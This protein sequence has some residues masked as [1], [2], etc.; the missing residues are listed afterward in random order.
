MLAHGVALGIDWA[1]AAELDLAAARAAAGVTGDTG[2]EGAAGGPPGGPAGVTPPATSLT[3]AL[4]SLAEA[5]PAAPLPAGWCLEPVGASTVRYRNK[6][7]GTV[8]VN[9]HPLDG[10]YREKARA[11][12]Q[13]AAARPAA[14]E[15]E[16][17]GAAKQKEPA[18]IQTG[19]QAK[20]EEGAERLRAAEAQV[21]QAVPLEEGSAAL[22]RSPASPV[23]M[24][25]DESPAAMRAEILGLRQEVASLKA[26]LKAAREGAATARKSP[27]RSPPKAL[28]AVVYCERSPGDDSTAAAAAA[29]KNPSSSLWSKV[30]WG[31]S[32]R[33]IPDEEN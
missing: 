25:E 1:Q 31:R 17:D 20:E 16:L 18:E 12:V 30:R 29:S 32:K 10:F 9:E 24:R 22:P 13:D 3:T 15:G 2:A 5:S 6:W 14:K 7:A 33:I 21:A 4:M 26:E 11:L 23:A 8:L 27:A 28:K 19:L